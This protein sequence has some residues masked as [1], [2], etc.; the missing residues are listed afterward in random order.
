MT[1]RP[2]EVLIAVM[3]CDVKGESEWDMAY[4]VASAEKVKWC[5]GFSDVIVWRLIVDVISHK[6]G[7]LSSSVDKYIE[8]NL[9]S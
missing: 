3:A 4:D 8:M 6:M 2:G 5:F 7:R 1:A 9:S